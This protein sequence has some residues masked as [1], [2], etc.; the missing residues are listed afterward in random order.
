[1]SFR[2]QEGQFS[3][4][5]LFLSLQIILE[6]FWSVKRVVFQKE[7]SVPLYPFAPSSITSLLTTRVLTKQVTWSDRVFNVLSIHKSRG[8]HAEE[9][10]EKTGSFGTTWGYVDVGEAMIK[11]S[12]SLSLSMSALVSGRDKPVIDQA[13]YPVMLPATVLADGIWRGHHGEPR[14]GLFLS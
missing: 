8:P 5:V 3:S 7:E 10:K 9:R 1:M 13:P 6:L 14:C 12:S 4:V 11:D 2:G